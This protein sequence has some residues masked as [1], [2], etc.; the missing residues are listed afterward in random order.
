MVKV[1]IQKWKPVGLLITLTPLMARIDFPYGKKRNWE[2]DTA[3]VDIGLKSIPDRY[4]FMYL[5]SQHQLL[6][7]IQSCACTFIASM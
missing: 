5:D 3:D 1:T 7:A 4:R 2:L 6:T